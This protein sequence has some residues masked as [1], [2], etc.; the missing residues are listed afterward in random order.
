MSKISRGEFIKTSSLALATAL[1]PNSL[2]SN[3]NYQNTQ[4]DENLMNRL[5][6]GNDKSV[7]RYLHNINEK[8]QRQYYRNLS[9][10]FAS[11][12]AAYC[13]PKSFYYKS[14]IVLSGLDQIINELLKLQYPNGTLDAGGNRQSPPDT[15]FLLNSLCPAANILNKN[16]FQEL[17]GVKNNLKTFL[18][19]AGEGIRKGGVHTPNHRWEVSSILARLYA[20][21]NDE[22]YIQ[23][24]D[25]WLSEG[26]YQNEDGNFP[27]RSRNYSVVENNAFII[28]GDILNRPKFF[29]I[30][31][32]S[33]ITNYYYL[34]SNGDLVCLDSRRQDAYRPIS[35]LH[36]YLLYRY[37]AIHE[38]DKF[39]AGITKEIETLEGFDRFVISRSLP[40]FMESSVLSKELPK[41]EKLPESYTKYIVKSDLVRMKRGNISASIFAG[42]DLP[43]IIASGRS[44]IPTFFTFRKRFAI[45]NYARLSTSFFNMG[46]VR[47][48]GLV[49]IGND[50]VM[51]E[52]KEAY[53]YLPLPGNL[54]NKEGDYKMSESVDRRFWSKMDFPDRPRTTLFQDSVIKVREENNEFKIDFDITGAENVEVTLDF[55]FREGGKLEGVFKGDNEDEYFLE[56]G[57]ATYTVGSDSINIG[58]GKFEH[59][60]VEHIDGEVYTSHFGSIKGTGTHLYI[61]GLVPFTHSITIK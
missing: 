58:P 4:E 42:N 11:L 46:Y 59:S 52:R 28:L 56:N 12:S 2:Y 61:T 60:N 48:N 40:F 29:E 8:R 44:C 9:G 35:I 39:F 14:K 38:N 33:L 25:E 15:A 23:R 19:N 57:Y 10:P 22:K 31:K 51:K 27:E 37:M 43:L 50:W 3:K 13:H 45:L 30:V 7:E 18:L 41:S 53:Y 34:E 55:C 20:L 1:A 54:R 26:I 17:A 47:G 24:I 6:K 21:F 16:D 49:K 5:V 36:F 32:K